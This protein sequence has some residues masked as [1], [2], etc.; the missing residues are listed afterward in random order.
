MGGDDGTNMRAPRVVDGDTGAGTHYVL[1]NNLVSR[2]SG[3]PTEIGVAAAPLRTDPTGTTTQPTGGDIAND[4][5][6]SGNPIKMG[7]KAL[8]ADPTA[9]TAGDRVNVQCDTL[10]VCITREARVDALV[11]G[12]STGTNTADHEII[13]APGA[14]KRIIVTRVTAFNTSASNAYAVIKSA[15]TEVDE[16]PTPANYGGGITYYGSGL[17]LSVNEALNFAANTSVTTMRVCANGY[18]V[19]N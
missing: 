18:V 4:A 10:G 17:S 2:D 15:T 1:E 14:G 6:D 5:A 8:A 16:I 3:G 19:S 9:V 11:K 13:A 12:C 7:G